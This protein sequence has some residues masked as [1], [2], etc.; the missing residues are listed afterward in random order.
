MNEVLAKIAQTYG[1]PSFVF[2]ISI[3]RKRMEAIKKLCGKKIHLCYSIKANP[4]L[5]P[6]M[7]SFECVEKLEV[8]SPGELDICKYY[9]VPADKIIYSGV[10]KTQENIHE[11]VEYNA[12]IYTAES[13]LQVQELEKEAE[14]SKKTLPVLLRLT[15]GSQFG[16][17]KELLFSII[18]K[19]KEYPHIQI[20]GIHYFAGTQ[21]KRS[22]DQ[23]KDLLLLKNIINELNKKY[24]F[25]VEKFEYGPGLP[26]PYFE[27]DDF[28]DTLSPIK[29]IIS[30]LN[31]LAE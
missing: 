30:D 13:L 10:N 29:N 25:T 24:H 23:E 31:N 20:K 14:I 2:D 7:L 17:S 28:S 8:C 5:I 15:A 16:M 18:E 9:K 11:A 21:R 26:F 6:A 27:G 4:F 12:G 1:S 22:S 3:L 19:Q